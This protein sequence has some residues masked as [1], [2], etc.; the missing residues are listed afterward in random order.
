MLDPD[1]R[2]RREAAN[3][4]GS[5]FF[6]DVAR[7]AFN[8]IPENYK[9]LQSLVFDLNVEVKYETSNKEKL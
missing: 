9:I 7:K 3:L 4:V 1:P 6:I 5:L 2:V 8:A